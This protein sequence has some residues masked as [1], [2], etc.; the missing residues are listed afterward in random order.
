M[1][2][3]KIPAYL[4]EAVK[5]FDSRT[6]MEEASRCLLCHDAPCSKAC[7]AGT[8]PASFIMSLRFRNIKGAA[9]T[10]RTA[11]PLGGVCGRVCPY[12]KLC[13][14]ACSRC[15]IDKPI[16]IGRLQSF[17][18]DQESLFG[19]KVLT[20]PEQKTGKAACIG[21]GP[22]SLSCAAV[23]A[24]AGVD[25]TIYE[26]MPK[27]G[28]LLAYGI[29]P[30]RLPNSVVAEEIRHI[31]DLGVKFCFNTTIGKDLSFDDLKARGYDAIFIGAGLSQ[32]KT[33]DIPGA[34]L[35]GVV[36][37]LD[38]LARAKDADGK[39]SVGERVVVIGGGDVAM[40]AAA[41]AALLGAK[42][43]IVYRRTLA[44]APANVDE[45]EFTQSLG[46]GFV[47]QFRP[48]EIVGETGKVTALKAVGTDGVSTLTLKADQ[49]ILAIGQA[50][51][52]EPLSDAA[53]SEK[54]L[55][56]AEN[57][58]TNIPGVFAGG[59]IVN[60]GKTVVQAVADGKIAAAS[61]LKYMGGVK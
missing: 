11:N 51:G 4:E 54:K 50:C 34:K 57:G 35:D 24:Q 14:Q 45:I 16:Q 3:K 26:K 22:A 44:E 15:G 25:V 47:F 33:L 42:T 52:D 18:A 59:D 1:S 41:T 17:A 46:V 6:A 39:I 60:G 2:I 27:A 8:D 10:I 28:G 21:A 29:I 38:F 61:M 36:S 20:A 13:E 7:P 58:A 56:L 31:E 32:A 49:V 43:T 37:A 40:D 12:D 30:S 48:D 55:I 9:E 19:M 53:R 23:L 5:P